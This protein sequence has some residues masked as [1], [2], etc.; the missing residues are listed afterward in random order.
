MKDM[1]KIALAQLNFLVG[2]VEGNAKKIIS[3]AIKARDEF[4]A[5]I[6]VFTE[7]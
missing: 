1:L 7:L 4:D 6:V 3:A 5:N 2:D